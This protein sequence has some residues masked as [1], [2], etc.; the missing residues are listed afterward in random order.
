MA[1]SQQDKAP[2]VPPI[3]LCRIVILF[4]HLFSFCLRWLKGSK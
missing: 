2:L 4:V 1:G 3:P